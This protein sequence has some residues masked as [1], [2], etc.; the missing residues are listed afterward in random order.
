M[1]RFAVLSFTTIIGLSSCFSLTASVKGKNGVVVTAHPIASQVGLDILKQGGNAFDAAVAVQ[2]A[3]AVVYPHA[4]NISGGGFLLY[5]D[6]TEGIG[7]LDFREKAPARAN[8]YM[9]LDAD[10]NVVAGLSRDGALS[11]GVPGS[12]AGMVALHERLGSLE[13]ETLI[14]PAIDIAIAGYALSEF[15]ANILNESQLKLQKINEFSAAPFTRELPFKA[16]DIIKIPEMAETLKLIQK[17]GNQGFYEGPT[18]DAIVEII[19]NHGGL[20]THKDLKT[21]QAIWRA[22]VLG[23][24]KGHQIYSM[25]PPSSGGIA[26]LQLLTGSEAFFLEQYAPNSADE[27]HLM[28]ELM[29]RVYADRATYLG[30]TDYVEVPVENLLDPNYIARRNA[31]IDL[32]HATP[33]TEI[34]E[35][36]VDQIESYETTHFSIVDKNGNAAAI[37]TTL[38]SRFGSKLYV[39]KAGFFLNNEMDDFSAKPGIPN[40]FGLVGSE[41]NAIESEKRMLSSMSPTIVAKDNQVKL[42]LG[43]PGGSTIITNVY[44]TIIN[45]LA[46]DMNL[47]A[48]VDDRKIH[49]Q[50][51]PDIISFE[52]GALSEE[53]QKT[54]VER[55]HELK[56][57]AQI[58]RLEAIQIHKN[59]VLEGAADESRAGDATALAF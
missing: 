7:A 39:P 51:L 49:A 54:L 42:V 26:V 37:T 33:S 3:L 5:H 25:S 47:Q 6:A 16:G 41:S 32:N 40:Q 57:I 31:T 8:R 35:G 36:K 4:G 15:E 14:Q 28:T 22:P 9:Y 38:N 43:T 12:V 30:D 45:V 48:A 53:A 46:H 59:G 55:G 13:W 23:T 44:Q 24:Y 27:A 20:M 10:G 56:E 11:V 19:Q 2:F 1:N 58:G 29:R 18:A 17:K 52:T 21:Y 50:W 34:K